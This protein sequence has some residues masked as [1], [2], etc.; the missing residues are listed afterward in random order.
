M[1]LI[2]LVYIFLG[3]NVADAIGIDDWIEEVGGK[4]HD[5]RPET[6]TKLK[7]EEEVT[8]YIFF[9]RLVVFTP[10]SLYNPLDFSDF[11]NFPQVFF[12]I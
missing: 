8:N 12:R 3:D 9:N 7:A 1:N 6:L 11:K 10:D 2:R 5:F 4:H